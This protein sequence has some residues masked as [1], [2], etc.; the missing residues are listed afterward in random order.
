LSTWKNQSG[1]SVI[2]QSNLSQM[3]SILDKEFIDFYSKCWMEAENIE[4]K[5]FQ[6][7]ILQ[8]MIGRERGTKDILLFCGCLFR[9]TN[10]EEPTM[11]ELMAKR[12]KTVK[13]G[14]LIATVDIGVQATQGIAQPW[15]GEGTKSF[16]FEQHK[17]RIREILVY[18]L[19]SKN[20]FR[21]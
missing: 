16:R 7:A 11:K 17:R 15:M 9:A 3:V 1:K 21:M 14:T 20:R 2:F 8:F 18:D 5:T 19:A 4:K 6:L 10:K 12:V 13:E